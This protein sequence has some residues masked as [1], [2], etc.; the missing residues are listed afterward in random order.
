VRALLMQCC[1]GFAFKGNGREH[2]AGLQVRKYVKSDLGDVIFGV[3]RNA[4]I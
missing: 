2:A 4:L 1:M 3:Q